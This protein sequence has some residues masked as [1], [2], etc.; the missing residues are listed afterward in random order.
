MRFRT[1]SSASRDGRIQM[2]AM[3]DI[4]FL[5]LVFFVMTFKIVAMEGQFRMKS[6]V[7]RGRPIAV[8][9]VPPIWIRLT[10]DRD[11]GLDSIR[12]NNVVVA[13]LK[14]L[15]NEIIRMTSELRKSGVGTD[16]LE[17]VLDCDYGLAYDHVIQVIDAIS[18]Y[19]DHA[20]NVVHLIPKI[21]FAPTRGS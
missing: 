21:R 16:K 18:G 5:L 8:A 9:D 3:I 7:Q 10:A 4:V 6:P 17:A 20:G 15:Q 12:V 19:K 11:G 2:S 1:S 14:G 13:N